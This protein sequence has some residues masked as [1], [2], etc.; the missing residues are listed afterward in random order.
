MVTQLRA[1]LKFAAE[2]RDLPLKTPVGHY[3]KLKLHARPIVL[4]YREPCLNYRELTVQRRLR[5][6][7]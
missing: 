1:N 5:T 6:T 2:A 3:Q 7:Q 4:E